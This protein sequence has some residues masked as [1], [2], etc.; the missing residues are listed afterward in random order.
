MAQGETHLG[1][2]TFSPITDR[3]AFAMLSI[4]QSHI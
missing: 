1:P 2:R 4:T 3:P